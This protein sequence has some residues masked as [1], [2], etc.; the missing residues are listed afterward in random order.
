MLIMLQA[1]F[2]IFD[3]KQLTA[4]YS[5]ISYFSGKAKK[6]CYKKAITTNKFANISKNK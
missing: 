3:T 4:S 1:Q 2:I 6:T 5:H